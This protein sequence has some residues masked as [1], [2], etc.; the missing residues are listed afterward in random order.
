MAPLFIMVLL[1]LVFIAC[2]RER[3][4][5]RLS[6]DE[7]FREAIYDQILSDK[8]MFDEFINKMRENEQSMKWMMANRP[9][10]RRAYG[11][12][13][14]KK[15]MLDSPKMRQRM[16]RDMMKMMHQDTAIANQMQRMLQQDTAMVNQMQQRMHQGR[17]RNPSKP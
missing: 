1:P 2:S 6:E 16:M 17:M 9:I 13:Q 8:K 3:D 15:M 4:T 12:N 10:M 14:M 5:I 7:E 11:R